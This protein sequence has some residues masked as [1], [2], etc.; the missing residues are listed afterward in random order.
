MGQNQVLNP[1]EYGKCVFVI[2]IFII[3]FIYSA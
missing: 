2:V 1:I 3:Q